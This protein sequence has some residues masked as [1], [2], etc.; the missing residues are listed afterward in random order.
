MKNNNRPQI[1]ALS[2]GN[3]RGKIYLT[4]FLLSVIIT[5]S[6]SQTGSEIILFDVKVKKGQVI[7]SNPKNITNR[8]GYDN[9][10]SF[11][12]SESLAYYSSFNEEG[13]SD[14][15]IY[16]YKT[17][18]TKALT[19]TQEREYSPTLTPDGNFIS[20]IIQRDNDAQD[21]GKY[22]TKGGTPTTLIDNL[23][24]GYHAWI[25]ADR[26]LLFVLGDPMTLHL[27]NIQTKEDKVVANHIGRSLHRIPN[28][29]SMSF[30]KKTT[31]TQ[32]SIMQLDTETL[33][34]TKIID[35]LPAHEDICWTTDGRILTS[36]GTKIYSVNPA[37]EKGWSEVT[38][39]TGSEFLKGVTRLA[40][41]QK[42][43]KLAVVITE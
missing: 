3:M 17:D 18:E 7:L 19:Q 15:K 40:I 5:N 25:D 10:P 30:I 33:T 35:C 32:W 1:L 13:R 11:H 37:K 43:D 22:P 12:R 21:L 9:Q 27:Y 23:K 31:D 4:I 16:N 39:S 14:I 29:K 20:C 24:V 8:K 42:G 26:L 36:D 38:L 2:M 28:K 34:I 6:F 41:N